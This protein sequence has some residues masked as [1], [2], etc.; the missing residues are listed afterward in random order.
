[1][2]QAWPE[3]VPES[4]WSYRTLASQARPFVPMMGI[5]FKTG[6]LY[7][8]LFGALFILFFAWKHF[9]REQEKSG[10]GYAILTKVKPRDL[11]G[12]G[13]MTRA[14]VIY[15][16]ALLVLYV[17]MTFFGKLILKTVGQAPLA[18][19]SVDTG[20]I[21]FDSA[22]WPLTLAFGFAGLAPL[23]PPLA[24]AENWLRDRA[25]R[26]VGIPVRI[27][28]TTRSIVS[29]LEQAAA[30]E[31]AGARD[32]RADLV[33]RSA[34]NAAAATPSPHPP[35]GGANG[36]GTN[37]AGPN[38]ADAN[39]AL[40]AR[41]LPYRRALCERINGCPWACEL[42]DARPALRRQLV[43][44]CAQLEL[45]MEWEKAAR[46]AWPGPEVARAVRDVEAGLVTEAEKLL[47]TLMQRLAERAA[48][49]TGTDEAAVTGRKERRNAYLEKTIAEARRLRDDLAAL[50]AV[51]L[52]RD[53]DLEETGQC[54]GEARRTK[55][56]DQ[57]LKTLLARVAP[58]NPA[59][60]GP[61]SGIL[62]CLTVVFAVYTVGA[63]RGFHTLIF[64]PGTDAEAVFMSAAIET[65]RIASIV[66]L[67]LL[68][69]FSLRQY[70]CDRHEWTSL[71]RENRARFVSQ[72]FAAL[73][74]ALAAGLVGLTCAGML[75]AFA[76]A[77]NA[78][79]FRDKLF[80]G[81][82]P[83]VLY[84]PAQTFASAIIVICALLTADA[85]SNRKGAWPVLLW[86]LVATAGAFAYC[87][88]F[89]H[90]TFGGNSCIEGRA[91]LTDVF[92]SR[93]CFASY[94]AT[95]FIVIPALALLST[96]V[97]GRYADD[98]PPTEPGTPLIPRQAVTTAA[99]TLPLVLAP[100]LATMTGA[101]AQALPEP[102]KEKDKWIN[103]GFRADAEPFSSRRDGADDDREFQGFIANL[104]YD[105]FKGG[106]YRIVQQEVTA[107]DRFSRV[108]QEP[109]ADRSTPPPDDRID[110]LC[111]PVTMRFSDPERNVGVFSPV[112]FASGVS[113]FERVNRKS[114]SNRVVGF[115]AGTTAAAVAR[116]VCEGD[117]FGAFRLLPSQYRYARC[118]YLSLLGEVARYALSAKSDVDPPSSAYNNIHNDKI[119]RLS[120]ALEAMARSAPVPDDPEEKEPKTR[121][122]LT[123][124]ARAG[125]VGIEK[126]YA[127]SEIRTK[128]IWRTLAS[129]FVFFNKYLKNFCKFGNC[130]VQAKKFLEAYQEHACR[131][132]AG[133]LAAGAPLNFCVMEGHEDLVKWFCG[134]GSEADTLFYLG[135]RELVRGKL[136]AWNTDHIRCD[137][138]L[139]EGSEART[140]EPYALVI[141]PTNM[142]L[143]R[144]VQRKVYEF[145]SRRDEAQGAFI[146]SFPKKTMS[147]PLAYLFLLN[148]VED[149]NTLAPT[150]PDD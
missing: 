146:G 36:A 101:W 143:V 30:I 61:E 100:L 77:E 133:T 123:S 132:Q 41:M 107:Q 98:R 102:L 27:E 128:I 144:F 26:A 75:H 22:Q 86:S 19:I 6:F 71:F 106:P 43:G 140:Y 142:D 54:E 138:Q 111:D 149:A 79:G 51:Y 118:K 125:G 66:W 74:V 68:C 33:Q 1:M 28:Q 10:S 60:I 80:G 7:A 82:W 99:V 34:F 29:Q 147:T 63:W 119:R 130:E 2:S 85:R 96:A 94:A 73:C 49:A 121:D 55:I 88:M 113:Y 4:L 92:Y 89:F 47:T 48:P 40:A 120:D 103:V 90:F 137:V 56:P 23:L 105:I 109:R 31:P 131:P 15:A 72:R 3:G 97:F 24:I 20:K 83:F 115:V 67:P 78:A 37:G 57:A 25:F 39:D 69:A 104:C 35:G 126:K 38:D 145:F 13:A 70:L 136:D 114:G 93:E 12:T 134:P 139:E 46:G 11:G 64:A 135:D 50:L 81:F 21:E 14:Y 8:F 9:T 18:G 32:A 84:Y 110:V 150:L 129:D 112:I 91:F 52:E 122:D 87:V 62:L 58:P 95:D 108:R 76:I 17:L 44:V 117:L 53:P 116:Q 148:A 124:W 141:T 16:F 65:L 127:T 42:L 5:D 59:G 45:L